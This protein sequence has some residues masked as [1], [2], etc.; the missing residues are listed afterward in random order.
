VVFVADGETRTN[1]ELADPEKDA[2]SPRGRAWRELAGRL[3]AEQR[4]V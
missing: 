2:A 4:P 3:A 1:A